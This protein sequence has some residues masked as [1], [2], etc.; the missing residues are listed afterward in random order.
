MKLVMEEMKICQWKGKQ[1]KAMEVKYRFLV[2]YTL[3]MYFNIIYIF[4]KEI[5]G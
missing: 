2:G 4:I 1:R 5:L 3:K